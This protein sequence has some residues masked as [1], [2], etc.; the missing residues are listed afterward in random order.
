MT[1]RAIVIDIEGTTSSIDFVYDI[2][3]P[4]A[5]KHL[6]DFVRENERN[7]NV[8]DILEAARKEAGELQAD[9]DQLIDIML[10][11]IAADQKITPLKT[12]QGKIWRH[13]FEQAD[14]T[15][16]IYVDAANCMRNWFDF[17]IALYIYSSGSVEAQQL[18]F[19]YSDVGDLRP[20]IAG[21]FDTRIGQKREAQSYKTI[22]GEIGLQPGEILF[23][24]DVTEELDAAAAAGMRT[25]QLVR[26]ERS[27]PGDHPVAHDFNQVA[28]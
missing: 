3:F 16:H 8:S 10:D 11:W 23:L 18:L 22:S 12:L 19:G 4:Y 25:T 5:S 21:Y 27:A 24:S 13:G 14:F 2:L 9:T 6:P 15:G 28:V 20:I 7:Q 26:D 17:G 1:T